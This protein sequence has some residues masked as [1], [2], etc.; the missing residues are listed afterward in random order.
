VDRIG[1]EVGEE[2]CN[3]CQGS[4]GGVKRKKESMG[5]IGREL[6]RVRLME[7]GSEV[8]AERERMKAERMGAE[9]MEAE[10]RHVERREAERREVEM[11]FEEEE[12]RYRVIRVERM[13]ERVEIERL[14]IEEIKEVF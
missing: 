8:E 12:Q 6:G 5:D 9:R 7:E 4:L 11:M 1:C 13:R 10:R 2:K 3:I 14:R